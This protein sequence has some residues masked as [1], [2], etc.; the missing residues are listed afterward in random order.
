LEPECAYRPLWLVPI[1]AS[2]L[3]VRGRRTAANPLPTASADWIFGGTTEIMKE[4]IAAA[5][6]CRP[7]R[8]SAKPVLPGVVLTGMAI[9]PSPGFTGR[10]GDR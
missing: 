7:V 6:A 2:E 9:V 5:S 4:I 8:S 3:E 10:G 1:A